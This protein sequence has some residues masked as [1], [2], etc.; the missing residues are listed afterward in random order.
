MC[1]AYDNSS[2]GETDVCANFLGPGINSVF[3]SHSLL[4]VHNNTTT[5]LD[6]FIQI[7]LGVHNNTITFL[8]EFIQNVSN[9]SNTTDKPCMEMV[10]RVICHYYL[11]PCGN[12]THPLPPSSLC[13]EECTY[14]QTVCEDTW[15]AV[16]SVFGSD[17]FIDCNDTSQ[18]LFPIPSCCT[19]AGIELPQSSKPASSSTILSESLFTTRYYTPPVVS[20]PEPNGKIV[21]IGVAIGILFLAVISVVA[22]VALV[23]L[24]IRH[25]NN[26]RKKL[27]ERMQM[28]ILAM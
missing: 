5:F 23:L 10:S 4:G 15:M 28:D 1:E 14:V 26:H 16:A 13:Q 6:E 24:M 2:I 3:L 7:L 17:Q 21:G 19:G 27:M 25:R 11:P 8:D 20:Q 12:I 9:I 18:L 22:I